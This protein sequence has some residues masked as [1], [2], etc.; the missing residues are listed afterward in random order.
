MSLQKIENKIYID[1]FL[2]KCLLFHFLPDF[3]F[4]FNALLASLCYSFICLCIWA[5]I[6]LPVRLSRPL[7]SGNVNGI[8]LKFITNTKVDV[9]LKWYIIQVFNWTQ[10]KIRPFVSQ[11]LRLANFNYIQMSIIFVKL[12]RVPICGRVIVRWWVEWGGFLC[13]VLR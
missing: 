4:L 5:S 7:L 10:S 2:N 1:F 9:S 6:D 8:K 3:S 13:W 12:R 11:N